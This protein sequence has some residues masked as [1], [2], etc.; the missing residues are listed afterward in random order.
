MPSFTCPC[1]ETPRSQQ[2]FASHLATHEGDITQYIVSKHDAYVTLKKGER[3]P[4]Y[5]CFGCNKTFATTTAASSHYK[6][7]EDCRKKHK[8]FLF[9]IDAIADGAGVNVKLQKENVRLRLENENLRE[10]MMADKRLG[11]EAGLEKRIKQA[12]DYILM[13]REWL[14]RWIMERITPEESQKLSNFWALEHNPAR[15]S[16]QYKPPSDVVKDLK[17]Q[18]QNDEF[19]Q[20]MSIPTYESYCQACDLGPAMTT[21]ALIPGQAFWNIH[22]IPP[23]WKFSVRNEVEI[24]KKNESP[25]PSE[26]DA[27]SNTTENDYY[28][29]HD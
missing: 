23:K 11:R 21:I 4:I 29:E 2:H 24:P 16:S 3:E 14:P 20:M 25:S 15:G 18:L 5:C 8:V 27:T 7:G 6:K 12:E 26:S 22:Y 17:Q 9:S 13:I 28:S 19:L 10:E 1:C